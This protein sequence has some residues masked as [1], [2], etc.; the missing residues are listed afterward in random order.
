MGLADDHNLVSGISMSNVNS[1]GDFVKKFQEFE[2][3]GNIPE[4]GTYIYIQ[5]TDDNEIGVFEEDTQ[6]LVKGD[7][8]SYDDADDW[9]NR[10]DLVVSWRGDEE[11]ADGGK[12]SKEYM[13][14]LGERDSQK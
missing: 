12:V 5:R 2:E 1:F 6:E 13:N 11:Y 9:A 7:F 10:N 14:K 3:G 8:T 4:E